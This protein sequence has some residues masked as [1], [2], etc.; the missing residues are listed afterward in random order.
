MV[1][2]PYQQYL[3]NSIEMAQQRVARWVNQGYGITMNVTAIL[4][5]L[6]WS[7]LSKRWQCSRFTLLLYPNRPVIRIPQHC[8]SST[9]T[10]YTQRTHYITSHH[11]R[12]Y[13][14]FLHEFFPRTITDW[15]NLPHYNI[16]S[17][18][19]DHFTLSLKSCNYS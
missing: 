7:L 17:D 4:N 11:S 12:L 19:L 10:H 5:N 13:K 18:T 3:I 14:I 1:L 8:L 15:N 16:E 9:S 6:E 2:D